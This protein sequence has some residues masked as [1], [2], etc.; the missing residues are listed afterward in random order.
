MNKLICKIIYDNKEM[1][2]LLSKYKNIIKENEIIKKEQQNELIKLEQVNNLFKELAKKNF[3]YG[4]E[5]DCN[6]DNLDS[7]LQSYTNIDEPFKYI[8]NKI[9]KLENK[10]NQQN[11]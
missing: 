5:C 3:Q 10:L 2:E 1:Y 7:I 4:N 8:R 6:I 11:Y 9:E